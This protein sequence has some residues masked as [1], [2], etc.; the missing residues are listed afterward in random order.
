MRPGPPRG[1]S[2]SLELTVTDELAAP[3]APGLPPV[4]TAPALLA[5]G[6]E[7][8]HQLVLAHLETGEVVVATKA[9]ITLRQP[10]AVGTVATVTATV[11][12]VTPTS[13]TYEVLV[14]DGDARVA[15]GSVEHR[16]VAVTT[17]AAE[18][19]VPHPEPSA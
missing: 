10:L 19:G 6:D 9:D 15:R 18:L 4:C 16:V 1:D 3:L 13:V 5:A 2:T 17:L 11:A 8:C 7:A 14:L 12:F